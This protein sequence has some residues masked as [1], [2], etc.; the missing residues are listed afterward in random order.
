LPENLLDTLLR[1]DDHRAARVPSTLEHDMSDEA[2]EIEMRVDGV[3]S[4]DSLRPVEAAIRAL[5]PGATVRLDQATG[6]I[7]A[8]TRRD[9]LEVVAA[10]SGAGFEATAMT[11]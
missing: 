11:L 3:T 10:L 6:I 7:H 4:P 1:T 2:R 9:T 5:D 8:T